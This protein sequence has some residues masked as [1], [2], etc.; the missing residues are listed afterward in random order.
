MELWRAVLALFL[1]TTN[2]EWLTGKQHPANAG[3]D[4]IHNDQHLDSWT[5]AHRL[6]TQGRIQAGSALRSS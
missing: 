1:V 4:K 3:T 6:P 2:V 5:I